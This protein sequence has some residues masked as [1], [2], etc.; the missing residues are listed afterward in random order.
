MRL[1]S[2]VA[3]VAGGTAGFG[4]GIERNRRHYHVWTYMDSAFLQ[5]LI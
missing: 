2:K 5:R 3:I 4:A 1:Q